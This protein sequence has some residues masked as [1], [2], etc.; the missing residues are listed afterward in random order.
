MRR[1]KVAYG[2]TFN[3]GNYESARIDIEIEVDVPEN[4]KTDPAIDKLF[5]YVK[6]KVLNYGADERIEK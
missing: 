3:I 6:L 5:K 1:I 4:G 2:R